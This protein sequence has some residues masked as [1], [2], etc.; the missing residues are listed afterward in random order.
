VKTVVIL[1]SVER[2]LAAFPLAVRARLLQTFEE[3]AADDTLG[4]S[5]LL[6]VGEHVIWYAVDELEVLTIANLR[7]VG[8]GG[9]YR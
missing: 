6:R 9:P 5:G 3:M 7:W 2:Q 1:R 4:E 8:A